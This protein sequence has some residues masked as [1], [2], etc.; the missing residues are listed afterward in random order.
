MKKYVEFFLL[1]AVIIAP[2]CT[3]SGGTASGI[4]GT[5]GLE[6]SFLPN[7]PP[8][9]IVVGKDN[10]PF[11]VTLEARN[12]GTYS[13][14]Q[15]LDGK[16]FLSGYDKNIIEFKDGHGQATRVKYLE[17]KSQSNPVGGLDLFEFS[18]NVIA[19]NL[20]ADTYDF[21]LLATACYSYQ[22]KAGPSVCIDPN[23]YQADIEKSC[24]VD[25]ISL[26]SQGAPIAV[27]NVEEEVMTGEFQFKI[28]IK[29]V[30]G[31]QAIKTD[32]FDDC[33]P[34]ESRIDLKQNVDFIYV[35]GKIKI[36]ST[37]LECRP[38]GSDNSIRLIEGAGYIICTLPNTDDIKRFSQ[39]Y[40][41]PI[42]IPLKYTYRTSIQQP[43]Q[44]IKRS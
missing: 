42:I 9:K 17:G 30:G 26:G 29:N 1:L 15:H 23:P 8:A 43:I 24:S 39:G 41:T 34:F 27:T 28:T 11:G 32:N 40:T 38:I 2:S 36:G 6:M 18:G 3:K 14:G 44:V 37:D 21:N 10:T 20:L 13:D 16:I 4:E 19:G 5:D 12:S 22:T 33:N 7:Q 35:D 31:G 25:A